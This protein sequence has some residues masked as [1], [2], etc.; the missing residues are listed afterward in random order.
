MAGRDAIGCTPRP[1]KGRPAGTCRHGDKHDVLR[2]WS[3]T[4]LGTPRYTESALNTV[5]PLS[6]LEDGTKIKYFTL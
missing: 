6:K 5:G 2:V 1:R 4:L 3:Y